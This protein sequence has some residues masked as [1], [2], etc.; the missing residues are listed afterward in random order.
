V[1]PDPAHLED[2]QAGAAG[3]LSVKALEKLMAHKATLKMN[4]LG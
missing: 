2:L 1:K 3:P 4:G